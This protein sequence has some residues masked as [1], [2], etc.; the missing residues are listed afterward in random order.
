M[1]QQPAP[2]TRGPSQQ[3][4]LRPLRWRLGLP[5]CEEAMK[6]LVTGGSWV[7]DPFDARFDNGGFLHRLRYGNALGLRFVRKR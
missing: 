4:S 3:G 7:G 2:R 1:A 5:A 6:R